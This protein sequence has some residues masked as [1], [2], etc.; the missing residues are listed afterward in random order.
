MSGEV[1]QIIQQCLE[2]NGD[3]WSSLVREFSKRAMSTL[4]LKYSGLTP[5]DRDDIIQNVF[6]RLSNGGLG[7][8]KGASQ[9]EFL[10]YFNTILRNEALRHITARNRRSI[11]HT[12][13]NIDS[14]QE[15]ASQAE[16]PDQNLNSQPD[17]QVEAQEMLAVISRALSDCSPVDQQVFLLKARGNKDR[18]ISSMLNIPLGT[19]AVKYS[20]IKDKLKQFYLRAQDD[21]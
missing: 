19:V 16:Y 4:F 11:E 18:E 9:Y 20:R 1:I 2:G 12:E 7:A 14:E 6:L 21:S 13:A 10:A 3:A 5:D 17:R 15:D 8:F